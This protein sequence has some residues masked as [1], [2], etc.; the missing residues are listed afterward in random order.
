MKQQKLQV[1]LCWHMHQPEYRDARTREFL[2]PWTYLHAM[3]D[4]SDMAAHLER[5][6]GARAVVNFST[7][8]LDQIADYAE[9]LR[10]WVET[11][12]RIGDPLLDALAGPLPEDGRAR[13]RLLQVAL[14]A[15][16]KT[17]IRPFAAYV[18]LAERARQALEAG[19]DPGERDLFDL[20][21]WYQLAWTG[22]SLRRESPS[23]RR[24]F[25][26]GQGF[27]ATDA[28]RLL[29]LGAEVLS[30][31]LPRYRDLAQAG[32][33]E[34][35]VTPHAHPIMPLLLDLGSARDAM[36]GV[37]LP[38]RP[39]PAGE[40]RCR[41]HIEQAI[42]RFERHFGWR[43]EGCWPAEGSVSEDSVA[44]LAEYG[45]RWCASGTNVLRHT[46]GKAGAGGDEHLG[47]WRTESD[48]AVFFRDDDLSDRI[49]FRYSDWHAD[50]AVADLAERLDRLRRNWSGD[51]PPTAV[52]MLD[53]EN[54][55]E[56]FP[57]NGWYFLRQLYGELAAHPGIECG[58]F[59]SRLEHG[60]ARQPLPRLVAGSWVYGNFSIWI[61]DPAK[62]RAWEQLIA[63][64]EALGN[65]PAAGAEAFAEQ[66][67]VC[68]A[69]DWFWWL[70]GDNDPRNSSDFDRLY[71]RHLR[72]LYHLA[73]LTVPEDLNRAASTES[74]PAAASG[75]S[76]RRADL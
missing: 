70:G 4:Y 23:L 54:A 44:L 14:R 55:W 33:I 36:P 66:L 75:G 20:L 68:E 25:D 18:A 1:V 3:K 64:R 76:M 12:R 58:T 41:W 17:M 16:E 49:G 74:K 13:R 6:Q 73:G 38:A 40:A 19:T 10:T 24:L 30:G 28:R 5:V 69:S 8:L 35:S 21:V 46:L 43:P 48:I 60:G 2:R 71:R 47:L 32:K 65:G 67:A 72:A 27:T 9:R 59:T 22:E 11:G 53:G 63:A 51:G 15:N 39:Y 62:N 29:T 56:H 57:Y 34:L 52:I 26:K 61:G 42:E 37:Q 7:I 50:D 31:L 45:F